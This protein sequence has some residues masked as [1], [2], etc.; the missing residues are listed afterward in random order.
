MANINA[1]DLGFTEEDANEIGLTLS[2]SEE[3]MFIQAERIA[4]E[5]ITVE[6][7]AVDA[8]EIAKTAKESL[9]FLAAL[10]MPIVFQYLFPAIF[11]T[12][13]LWL[14]SYVHKVRDF[15]Q[16]CLGLP[17][18]FGKSTLM[19]IFIL[20]C[21]LFTKKK[22]ILVIGST[23]KLAENIISDVVDMLS[24]PNIIAVFGDWRLGITKDTQE[25]KKFGFRGRNI[26]LAAVGW[27]GA[28]RGLNLKNERPDIMLFDDVQTRECA[29]SQ[30]ESDKLFQWMI[31]TAMKAKSPFGCLYIFVGN[32]YPTKHSILRKLKTNTKWV[33]FIAGGIL[34]D[35][36]SLWEELQPIEQLI[37]E[38]ESDME[39][40]HP[41]IF[42]AEVLNDENANA[43]N[44]V[45]FNKLPEFPVSD[46]DIPDGN[47]II[48]D[49]STDKA[50][51]DF[52][53][54]GYFEIHNTLPI[55]MEHIEDRLSP[56]D[57]IRKSLELALRKNC[58]LICV[59]SNAYQYSLLYWFTFICEQLGIKGINCL[60][61]Y[62]GIASKNTR[63]MKML[64][65]YVAGEIYIHPRSRSAC[66]I[67]M[68]EFNPL[69]RDNTDGLLDLLTY[70]P[71]VITMYAEYIV[72]IGLIANQEIDLLE[73]PEYNS[74]F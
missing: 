58:R 21:I 41:E 25:L 50:K 55:L 43:N 42:F 18:G 5:E 29:D 74:C 57:T 33:K 71:K 6:E 28:L 40:G 34:A 52:V 20:Y 73:V 35:C 37:A 61:I 30:N 19:K 23:A 13:W 27:G 31:G 47:F 17:R 65:S 49:P 68:M 59:E 2:P 7:V 1:N 67:Q 64:R 11:Q 39:S 70:A 4:Y 3:E 63:I 9:D 66:H 48:I 32:M 53:S 44:L 51:S 54:I 24:E 36:T 16:L 56:G 72:S 45:D 10:A 46:N 22:F 69:K 62:S 14:T 26:S 8:Q 12:V 15:S 60:D 38:Y